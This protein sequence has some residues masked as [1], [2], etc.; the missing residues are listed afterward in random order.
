ML[1]SSL[2][3]VLS[4]AKAVSVVSAGESMEADANAEELMEIGLVASI[5][6]SVAHAWYS[7]TLTS[8]L[9]NDD[10]LLISEQPCHYSYIAI[11]IF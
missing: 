1:L 8:S 9:S 2:C 3:L 6:M 11:A 4:S 10:I 5:F 7:C